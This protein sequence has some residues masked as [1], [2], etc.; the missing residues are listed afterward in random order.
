MRDSSVSIAV[1][2]AG[3]DSAG[4]AGIQ[5]D[6]KSFAARGVYGASVITAVTAQNTMGVSAV[7]NVPTEIVAKQID[8]VF[9]DLDVGAVKIGMVSSVEIIQVIAQKLAEFEIKN[10]V[11]DPVMVAESG[12]SLI[13]Q[14]AVEEIVSQLFPKALVVT[15]NLHEAAKLLKTEIA[16]NKEEMKK[17]ALQ[18][19]EMGSENVIVKGG[20]SGENQ[21]CDVLI[22]DKNEYWFCHPFVETQNTHGTGCSLSSAI[23]AEIAKGE[24][25]VKAT[26]IAKEWL[27]GAIANSDKLNV[28]KGCGPVNHFYKLWEK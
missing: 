27:H 16:K 6:I 26:E 24:K 21:A 17:Q 3:S 9:D 13:E 14:E 4:G 22:H 15:P 25:I 5:A 20:H 23:A 11:L 7:H 18:L 10:V 1:T 28:G 8:A 12:D 19:S 2:I